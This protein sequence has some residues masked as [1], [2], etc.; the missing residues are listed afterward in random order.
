[1]VISTGVRANTRT[2][3]VS[4][5]GDNALCAMDHDFHV[6]NLVISV[7][8]RC[9]IPNEVGGSFFMGDEDD[10]NGGLFYTLRDAIFDASRIFDH[11]AQLI[12]CVKRSSLN[13][14]VLVLQTD[15]G[16]DHSIKFASTKN[17]MI[18]L[19]MSLDLDHLVVLRGAPNGSAYNKIERAM[20]PANSALA[21]VSVKRAVMPGWAEKLMKNSNS[22][23]EVRLTNENHEKARDNAKKQMVR[24]NN[25]LMMVTVKELVKTILI[26]G[27]QSRLILLQLALWVGWELI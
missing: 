14:F 21:N 17:A 3:I 1:M 26:G 19:F 15:G 6:V 20:S 24:L 5:T 2:A 8:L 25:R 4:A 18:A 13:P 22:M 10:G 27:Q 16:P 9:N 7:T 11:T 23:S 12:D